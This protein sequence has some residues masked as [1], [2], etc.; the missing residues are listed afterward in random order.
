MNIN[1]QLK[2]F[3]IFETV[4]TLA[5]SA[6][7]IGLIYQLYLV[8]SFQFQNFN[9]T[10]ETITEYNGFITLMTRDINEAIKIVEVNEQAMALE[11][12]GGEILYSF[13]KD[14]VIRQARVRD[15]FHFEVSDISWTTWTLNKP[16]SE[17]SIEF[18]TEVLGR[19]LRFFESKKVRISDVIEKKIRNEY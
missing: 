18:Y 10:Q 5:V 13:N 12:Q 2:A 17:E 7:L 4:V 9:R 1:R 11:Y 3:T 19:K 16:V 8:I 14:Q 6:I 15:T